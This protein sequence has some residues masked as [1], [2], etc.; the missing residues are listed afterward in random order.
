MLYS[1][2][3]ID[4]QQATTPGNLRETWIFIVPAHNLRW[5]TCG[6]LEM[7]GEGVKLCHCP[8]WLCSRYCTAAH[9]CN[10]TPE[11][12][13]R[14]TAETILMILITATPKDTMLKPWDDQPKATLELSIHSGHNHYI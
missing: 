10:C 12:S 5:N 7:V 4:K 13:Y 3:E 9:C 14:C 8:W 11:C 6:P 1:P 2:T